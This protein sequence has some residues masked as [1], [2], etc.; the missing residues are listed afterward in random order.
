M[1]AFFSNILSSKNNHFFKRIFQ[2]SEQEREEENGKK[3]SELIFI[4]NFNFH[5]ILYIYRCLISVLW[6]RAG[7][8][9]VKLKSGN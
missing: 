9:L 3:F 7:F 5:E 8:M 1:F 2:S 6:F 4:L